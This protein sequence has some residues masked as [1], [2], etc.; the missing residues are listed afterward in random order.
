M[1][2]QWFPATGEE[3]A[4]SDLSETTVGIV[5]CGGLLNITRSLMVNHRGILRGYRLVELGC[6]F[7]SIVIGSLFQTAWGVAMIQ[8]LPSVGTEPS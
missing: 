7:V 4:L 6:V 5:Q 3:R 2:R 8:Q 1:I